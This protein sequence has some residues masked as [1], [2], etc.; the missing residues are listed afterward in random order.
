M[1]FELFFWLKGPPCHNFDF[2]VFSLLCPNFYNFFGFNSFLGTCFQ[3]HSWRFQ[4]VCEKMPKRGAVSK[5]KKYLPLL[6]YM[7]KPVRGS[8][9]SNT[10]LFFFC[11]PRLREN[12]HGGHPFHY[13]FGTTSMTKSELSQPN[14]N[15]VK[16][17]NHNNMLYSDLILVKAF[18]AL[19]TPN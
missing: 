8:R 10:L 16:Q 7:Y 11:G 15:N 13:K 12:K 18:P 6:E 19:D 2:Y 4:I 14:W 5:A 3:A 17:D 9:K 1:L